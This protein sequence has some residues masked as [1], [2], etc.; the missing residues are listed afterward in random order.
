M[1][2]LESFG[3]QELNANEIRSF[4]GGWD[5]SEAGRALGVVVT[6]MAIH[7]VEGVMSPLLPSPRD[8]IKNNL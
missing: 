3:V 2:N 7:F 4:G 5:W 6:S 1:K 8:T